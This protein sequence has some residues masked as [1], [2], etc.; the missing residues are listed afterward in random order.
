MQ[1][2]V[3]STA[4]LPER[5]RFAYWRHA[6]GELGVPGERDQPA[7][8]KFAGRLE[9]TIGVPYCRFRFRS[10]KY[11]VR[12]TL[13]E[14]SRRLGDDRIWLYREIG[15]GSR[16]QHT[17]REFVTYGGDV[18]IGDPALPGETESLTG[19]DHEIWS[20][21][22]H[23]LDP[24]LA[25]V[26]RPR[27]LCLSHQNGLGAVV[28]SYLAAL[29]AQ[30]EAL[31][32][33]EAAVVADNFCRLVAVAVGK[34]EGDHRDALRAGREERLKRYI[35]AHL[36]DPEL[37]AATVA[38]AMKMCVRQVH[39]VFEP[40]GMSFGEYVLRRRLEECRSALTAASGLRRS[41][42]DIA[43]AWGFNSL[44][45][46]YRTFRRTFGVSPSEIRDDAQA[47]R[48]IAGDSARAG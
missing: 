45:T 14:L 26:R 29:S 24:H 8:A 13:G 7:D 6:V 30:A 16:H 35:G 25:A 20:F 11:R 22:R 5:E 33:T 48:R 39:S 21:P 44:P 9:A 32:E 18:V 31:D 15:E 10:G 41:V 47:P 4:G 23:L 27:L 3:L 28:C 19:Y 36:S 34:A 38:A 46:F 2:I 40:T 42:T 17:G 12:R 43:F 1:H 37:S